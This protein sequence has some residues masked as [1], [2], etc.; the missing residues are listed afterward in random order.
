MKGRVLTGFS[1]RISLPLRN[2]KRAVKVSGYS[3]CRTESGVPAE[4]GISG[5]AK[6]LAVV[7]KGFGHV[8]A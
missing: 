8:P 2:S 7:L 6:I 4:S 3:G 5:L 1:K